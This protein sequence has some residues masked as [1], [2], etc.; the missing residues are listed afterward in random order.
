MCGIFNHDASFTVFN[1]TVPRLLVSELEFDMPCSVH[2]FDAR[3]Y[4]E[5]A[6]FI[7][8]EARPNLPPPAF[9]IDLYF[10]EKWDD[11]EAVIVPELTILHH[12][13][14]I[15]GT[16]SR[17]QQTDLNLRDSLIYFLYRA[18]T[19]MDDE[20]CARRWAV[21]Q[22]HGNCLGQ[23][24]DWMGSMYWPFSPRRCRTNWVCEA[25]SY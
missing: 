17:H 23:M 10:S 6:T 19:E 9:L 25:C 8:A 16:D 2:V 11:C 5:C 20:K 18:P 1:N 15:L 24:E 14:I 7:L 21:I 12:F 4:Q 3:S 13:V 22:P